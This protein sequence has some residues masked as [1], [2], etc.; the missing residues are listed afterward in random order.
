VL[1]IESESDLSQGGE[2]PCLIISTSTLLATVD[3]TECH[4][5]KLMVL[6]LLEI[7][8]SPTK[9]G[10]VRRSWTLFKKSCQL[11]VFCSTSLTLIFS[12]IERPAK[13]STQYKTINIIIII[14]FSESKETSKD[15]WSII[16]AYF[17]KEIIQER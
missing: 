14:P 5:N 2:N 15:F 12:Y 1:S 4:C 8:K 7:S 13:K 3:S 17:K 9:Y 6:R 10:T 16:I 11:I